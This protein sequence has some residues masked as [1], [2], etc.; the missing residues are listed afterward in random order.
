MICSQQAFAVAS[1]WLPSPTARKKPPL[2]RCICAISSAVRAAGSPSTAKPL[3][4]PPAEHQLCV[5]E[6]GQIHLRQRL[7]QAHGRVID[8]H[9]H[10]GAFNRRALTDAHARRNA[11]ENRSLR[12][13]DGRGCTGREII[14]LQIQLTNQPKAFAALCHAAHKHKAVFTRVCS[15]PRCI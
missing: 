6:L 12:R 15:T 13:A 10:M 11:R 3:M 1:E 2:S 5:V 14:L 7:D 4:C 9:H 8:E